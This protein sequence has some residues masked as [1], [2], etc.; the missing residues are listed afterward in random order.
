MQ[1]QVF[2]IV[3]LTT[4]VPL[5]CTVNAAVIRVPDDYPSVLAG[6]DAAAAGDSVLV[7]PGTWTDRA[8]RTVVVFGSPLTVESAMYLKPGVTVIGTS[9]AEFT[10]LDGGPLGAWPLYTIQRVLSGTQAA[11]VVGL[12]VTGGGTGIAASGSSPLE[13][14]GCRVVSN[15]R[16]GIT[17]RETSLILT[18]CLIAQNELNESILTGGVAGFDLSVSCEA[19]TFQGNVGPGLHV[20]RSSDN[21]PMTVVLRDCSFLDHQ[22]R[23]AVLADVV[24]L[25]IERCLFLRNRTSSAGA[26]GGLYAIRCTGSLRFSTFAFDSAGSG[27]GASLALSLVGAENNTFYRCHASTQAGAL[28]LDGPDA[29][30]SRNIF[31]LSTGRRGA[32]SKEGGP[33]IA[34]TGCNLFWG[35]ADGD[36]YGDWVPAPT[37]IHADPLFC[38]PVILDF[39]LE[40]ASPAAPANSGGCGLIGAHDVSCGTVPVESD[41][42]GRIKNQYRSGPSDGQGEAQ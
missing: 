15:A 11:R 5:S 33:T 29:G 19:C 31:A 30:T 37:D 38:D 28:Y 20:E 27:G 14:D 24:S 7:G 41:T 36:Y 17:A 22:L 13:L 9:G 12:T 25:E 42:W 39:G 35:S 26:G 18:N 10:T 40:A 32:V 23:G 21:W 8:V 16:R 6:A 2:I 3:G 34:E 1:G 4:L